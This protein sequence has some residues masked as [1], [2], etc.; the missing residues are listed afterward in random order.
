MDCSLPRSSVHGILQARTLQCSLLQGIF[1]TQGTNPSLLHCR[2][3]LYCLSH[4]ESPL[5]LITAYLS[6]NWLLEGVCEV[7]F[8]FCMCE[9]LWVVKC[10]R[11]I[12]WELYSSVVGQHGWIPMKQ[13]YQY[14]IL[15]IAYIYPQAANSWRLRTVLFICVSPEHSIELSM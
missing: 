5:L 6:Y 12:P 7:L 3:V 9:Y 2:Q 15:V 10:Y 4:Q 14:N 13:L 8:H 1:S 11:P